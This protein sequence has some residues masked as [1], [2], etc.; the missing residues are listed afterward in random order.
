MGQEQA[1]IFASD[2]STGWHIKDC[3]DV[4]KMIAELEKICFHKV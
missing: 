2:I 4:V 1:C 3:T